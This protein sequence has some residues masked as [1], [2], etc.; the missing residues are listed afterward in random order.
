MLT[1]NDSAGVTAD[2]GSPLQDQ[3]D[4]AVGGRLPL[5]SG[6]LA[7]LEGVT[8]DGNAE[9]V[10]LAVR[11]GDGGHGGDSERD[12]EAHY[13]WYMYIGWEKRMFKWEMRINE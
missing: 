7:D 8:L 4:S 6:R 12:E 5:Q 11:R 10:S 2:H 13:D 3:T 1:G 9:G